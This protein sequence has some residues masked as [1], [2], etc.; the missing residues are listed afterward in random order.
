MKTTLKASATPRFLPKAPKLSTNQLFSAGW[1]PPR[2]RLEL[3][4]VPGISFVFTAATSCR[5][6][7]LPTLV[8]LERSSSNTLSEAQAQPALQPT[9]A[10]LCSDASAAEKEN[11]SFT[12]LPMPM[13]LTTGRRFTVNRSRL[14]KHLLRLQ[15]HV[16]NET[17]PAQDDA[18]Q[19]TPVHIRRRARPSYPS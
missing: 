11:L 17:Q 5:L 16:N 3:D 14:S 10:T 9:P 6:V 4:D 13:P 19:Q 18:S 12:P 2:C 8:P 1:Q 7:V 15:H